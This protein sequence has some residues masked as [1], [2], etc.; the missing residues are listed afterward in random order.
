M[1]IKV[2]FVNLGL[3]YTDIRT[4]IE[5]AIRGVLS[6]GA[7]I[8]GQ[9]VE[10]FEKK[11]SDFVGTKY[12]VGLNSGTDALYFALRS[13]GV[14]YKDEVITVS[15]TF[16]ATID[17][18]LHCDAVPVLVDINEDCLINVDEIER[19]IT[20]A[21]KAIIPVHLAG[22]IC[23]MGRIK[24][25]A[26]KNNLIVIED[27]AQ[28]LGAEFENKKAGAFGLVGCFSFYPTKIL[29]GC[30]DGGAIVTDNKVIAD[31]IRRLRD[32]GFSR[33]KYKR[34][35]DSNGWGWNSRLDNIQA[36]ILNIKFKYLLNYIQER[37]RIAELY[38]R[39][40]KTLSQIRLPGSQVYQSYIIRVLH[41]DDLREYLKEAG[42]ETLTADYSNRNFSGWL[43]TTDQMNKQALYLPIYPEMTEAQV[44][45]VIKSVKS[46]YEQKI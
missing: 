25:I 3:Q 6:K 11:L 32:H 33:K 45:Y 14:G 30:G 12:A 4:E 41:R 37:K 35:K 44:Y 2:P 38:N 46:F 42:I 23:D 10:A 27:S 43:P 24:E 13:A 21:T 1:S 16:S 20:P 39:K 34:I 9:E 36:S 22:N 7:F 40:L 8:L 5:G 28:A 19:A 15:Y 29:G 18:I 17:A 31:K 26:E